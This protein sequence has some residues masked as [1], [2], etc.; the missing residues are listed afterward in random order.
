M[1]RHQGPTHL[2]LNE[3]KGSDKRDIERASRQVAANPVCVGATGDPGTIPSGG[4]GALTAVTW[5][6]NPNPLYDAS[7]FIT[8]G[9]TAAIRIPVDG[10][11]DFYL[12]WGIADDVSVVESFACVLEVAATSS[13]GFG[14]ISYTATNLTQSKLLS[15]APTVD[16]HMMCLYRGVLASANDL[17][18]FRV[19]V[20]GTQALTN[21]TV[22]GMEFRQTY[23]VPNGVNL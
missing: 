6:P 2:R 21:T 15:Q 7:L 9:P 13:T 17:V 8:P 20:Y 3:I 5:T 1:P 14:A 19:Q 11:Y 12:K 4:P 16:R 18:R 10:F 22:T 23:P